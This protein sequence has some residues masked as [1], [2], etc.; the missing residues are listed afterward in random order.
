VTDSADNAGERAQPG[1]FEG[2]L[3]RLESGSH[4]S[5]IANAIRL[6]FERRRLVDPTDSNHRAAIDAAGGFARDHA[7]RVLHDRFNVATLHLFE[8]DEL[9]GAARRQWADNLILAERRINR[10]H[11]AFGEQHGA[12]DDVFQFAHIARPVVMLE[13][14]ERRQADRSDLL[15]KARAVFLREV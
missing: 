9:A 3:P 14:F 7:F 6:T 5:V 15:A 8:R 4:R 11:F 1:G 10:Q 12:F 13:S 2:G